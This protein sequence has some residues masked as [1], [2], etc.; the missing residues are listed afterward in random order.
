MLLLC[1]A[2]ACANAKADGQT[3]PPTV[4]PF[5]MPMK[6]L[7]GPRKPLA[8]L[9]DGLIDPTKVNLSGV[10]GV[11][12]AEQ[13]RAEALVRATVRALPRWSNVSVAKRD[14]YVPL[15]D[16]DRGYEH[17]VNIGYTIDNYQLDAQRP[18]DLLYQLEPG[19]KFK[20]VAAMYTLKSTITLK[21][22]PDL[23]GALTQWHVHN[24][25]CVIPGTFNAVGANPD[26]SCPRG[27]QLPKVSPVMIHVWIVPNVCGPFAPL[28]DPL[29]GDPPPG[30]LML[31]DRVHGS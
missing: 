5:S 11:T 31:C 20:L 30:Q 29:G 23:G 24:S 19:H 8:V 9:P 1:G 26:G 4:N 7:R 18:E 13:H 2:A 27:T 22:T 12:P 16:E 14:G 3:T 17:F 21:N 25:L 15:G 10:K 28:M 6:Y